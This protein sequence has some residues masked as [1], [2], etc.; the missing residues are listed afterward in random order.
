MALECN[1]LMD[2]VHTPVQVVSCRARCFRAIS[3]HLHQFQIVQN[4]LDWEETRGDMIIMTLF[5]HFIQCL[6]AIIQFLS[7]TCHDMIL[8]GA[9]SRIARPINS[10][11][12]MSCDSVLARVELASNHAVLAEWATDFLADLADCAVGVDYKQLC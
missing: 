1:I 10:P 3:V 4:H 6:L 7:S 5:N 12:D 11:L 9:P 8:L 2:E